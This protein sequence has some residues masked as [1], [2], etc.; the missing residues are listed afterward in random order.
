M[1]NVKLFVDKIVWFV[2]IVGM[3]ILVLIVILMICECC[4]EIGVLL[5]LGES[6]WKIVV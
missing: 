3:I 2:V 4:Y 5:L 1:N 6:C